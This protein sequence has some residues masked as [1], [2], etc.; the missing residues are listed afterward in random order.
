MNQK[1]LNLR[2]DHHVVT[3]ACSRP[4]ACQERGSVKPSRNH[5]G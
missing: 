3:R 2:Y 4:L 5:G 1:W